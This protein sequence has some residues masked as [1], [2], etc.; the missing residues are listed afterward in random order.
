ME[1][2]VLFGPPSHRVWEMTNHERERYSAPR[3]LV[4]SVERAVRELDPELPVARVATLDEVV[5]R[6][7]RALKS[8]PRDATD[9]E[10]QKAFAPLVEPLLGL[11]GLLLSFHWGIGAALM[12]SALPGVFTR[13]KFSRRMHAWQKE[14]TP[15]ERQAWYFDWLLTRDLHAKEI[16][17]LDLGA[18]FGERF[19]ALRRQ[20]RSDE[21]T[22]ADEPRTAMRLRF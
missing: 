19:S 7:I 4:P 10:A 15:A 18:L 13:W 11:A 5:A 3:S 17:L 14:R 16:R 1:S 9:E 20:L 8:L 12:L 6:S 21:A 2:H 22:V